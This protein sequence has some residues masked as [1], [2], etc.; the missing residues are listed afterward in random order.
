[1]RKLY[2]EMTEKEYKDYTELLNIVDAKKI[3]THEYLKLHG[4]TQTEAKMKTENNEK[5]F[6]VTYRFNECLEVEIKHFDKGK[7]YKQGE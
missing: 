1:M 6:S 4:F 3:D 7:Y 5:Y 2:V